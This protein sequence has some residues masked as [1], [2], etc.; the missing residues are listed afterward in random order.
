MEAGGKPGEVTRPEFVGDPLTKVIEKKDK[1]NEEFID[2]AID[3][4]IETIKEKLGTERSKA[5]TYKGEAGQ[6]VLTEANIAAI[7]K[8]IRS[9]L[10]K[11]RSGAAVS[12]LKNFKELLRG[13]LDEKWWRRYIWGAAEATLWGAGI[14]WLTMP[15]AEQVAAVGGAKSGAVTTK[16]FEQV[17]NKNVWHT[18]ETM[19]KVHL[20]PQQLMDLSQKVL[21]ANHMYESQWVHGAVQHLLSSRALPIGMHIK[22]PVEVLGAMGF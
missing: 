19:S 1:E 12:D 5:A 8:D 14:G 13:N 17:L 16:V 15:G 3:H 18:L 2:R 9:E 11:V 7:R 4:A 22:I 10:E 6:D 20:S 21:N